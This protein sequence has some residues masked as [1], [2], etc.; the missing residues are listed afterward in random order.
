MTHT[1]KIRFQGAYLPGKHEPLVDQENWQ[2]VQD[3]LESHIN[4]ERIR[5]H[6][7]FL[8]GTVYCGACGERLLIQYAKSRSGVRYPYYSCAGR[9]GKR[10]DCKQRS[11]LIEEVERQMEALY[12]EISFTPE[13]RAKLE[14]WLQA[15]IQK[16]A[17]EFTDE[18]HRLGREKDKLER[19]QRKLLEAHYADAIPLDLFKEEQDTLAYM[20][21]AIDRQL[22]LHDILFGK[23]KEKLSKSLAIMEGCGE[24]YQSAPEH[25]KRA[26]NLALFDKIHVIIVDGT[27]LITPQF[28]PPYGLIFG[29]SK[30][31]G[32]KETPGQAA[33]PAPAG[34]HGIGELSRFVSGET[35]AHIFFGGGFNKNL[36]VVPQGLEPRTTRL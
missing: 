3:V 34:W 28:A 7:H 36:L 20:I 5:E 9:H 22:D 13:L 8:K 18:K 32:Q 11:I 6:P 2:K 27:C 25:I 1:G 17:D 29:Q 10:N 31:S 15:E 30:D 33:I 19:K 26:Y 4:G 14:D 35:A 24:T 16:S 21:A 23:V 12:H